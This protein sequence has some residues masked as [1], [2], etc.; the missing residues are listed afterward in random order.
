[1][2]DLQP[3]AFECFTSG[4]FW[5]KIN[6]LSLEIKQVTMEAN[7]EKEQSEAFYAH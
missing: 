3:I 6:S 2:L 4:E 5:T 1:M 7:K